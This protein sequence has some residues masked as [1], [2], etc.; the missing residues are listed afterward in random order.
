M[1]ATRCCNLAKVSV[2]EIA[3]TDLQSWERI[4]PRLAGSIVPNALHPRKFCSQVRPVWWR[5]KRKSS[6][7]L[8][9]LSVQINRS[10]R[11]MR[12][13]LSFGNL[14][15]DRQPWCVAITLSVYRLLIQRCNNSIFW[16]RTQTRV[17]VHSRIRVDGIH[18][19]RGL[20]IYTHHTF[21]IITLH[22]NYFPY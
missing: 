15:A 14:G 19:S 16:R 5:W 12:K 7:G 10:R 1:I 9:S 22:C 17:S 2:Q 18:A 6:I 8:D 11:S 4:A 20:R 3:Y 13:G 21:Q